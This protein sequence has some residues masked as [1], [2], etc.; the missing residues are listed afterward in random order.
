MFAKYVWADLIRNPRRTLSTMIGV[1][2]GV[3]L[4]CAILFFVDG[5]SS[6]MTE[7]A[8]SPLPIDIQLVQTDPV[9][10]DTRLAL[11]VEPT[12][13]ATPGD[14]INVR[15][16]VRNQ[17][18]TP[19]NEVVVRSIPASGLAYRAGSA[20]MD[21]K[22]MVDEGE[23][24]FAS[25]PAKIGLNI[26]TVE[27]G[28]TVNLGYQVTVSQARDISVDAFASTISTREA[29]LPV[30]A[31]AGKLPGLAE[32]AARI[33]ALDGVSSAEQLSFV[34]LPHGSLSATVPVN[35]L[36]RL[37]GFDSSYTAQDRTITIVEGTQAPGEA[38]ISAEAARSLSVGIHDSIS[39]ML[40]DGTRL[41]RRISGIVDLTRARS[42]FLS[43]M[44]ENLE[45][46][47]YVPDSIVIDAAT[48]AE[49]V[50]PAFERVN[51]GRGDRI[52][53]L[54]LREVDVYVRRDLLEAEP[55]AALARTE[56]I[57]AAV[58]SV[59]EDHQ[60]GRVEDRGVNEQS[61]LLDNISNTLTVARDDAAVAKRMFLFLSI[62]GAMLAAL[63]GAYAGIVL[64][65]AQR[66]EQATLRV[67]GASR[68]NLLWMLW[69]RVGWITAGG[70][71]LGL[72]LGYASVAAVLGRSMLTRVTAESLIFSGVLG[73]VFGLMATGAA[74]YWTGRSTIDRGIQMDRLGPSMQPPIWQRYRLDLL[75]LAALLVATVI[76]LST[77]GFE[78]TPGSVYEG[79]AVEL[80]L[81]LLLLPIAAWVAGSLFGGRLFAWLLS[82][83]STRA[84][85]GSVSPLS[86]LYWRSLKRRSSSLVVA[87]LILGM[88]VALA[89]SLAVFTASYDAAKAADARYTVGSDLKII[90]RPSSKHVFRSADAST[91]AVEGIDTVVPVIYGIHNTQLRSYRNT[92][93][94]NLAALDPIAYG[95]VAPFDDAHFSNDSA[96][97][98]LSILANQP[99]AILLSE[100]M[101]EF[102][103]VREGDTIGVLLGRATAEQV[104][105][106]MKVQGLYERLPGFPDG[107]DALMN[108]ER[109]Q[110]AVASAA[111]AFFLGQTSDSSDALVE[112]T[113][114]TLRNGPGAGDA[115]RLDTRLTALGKDQSSLASLNINGL[116]KLDS[117]YSLA[118][119]T[120]TVA[121]FV[122]G[123]LLQ[124]RREYVTLR[125]QGM[126]PRAIQTFIGAEAGTAA[127]V[128]CSVGALVGLMM[129]Y[130]FINVLRPLFVLEPLYVV[131]LSSLSAIL[132]SVLA[133]TVVTSVAASALV[134]QLQAME[135]LRDE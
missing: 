39:V 27:A 60:Q 108:I 102:M 105:I 120:V 110:K 30:N 35:G 111:P 14:V 99:D 37:F 17:G 84:P 59:T 58:V 116:L 73:T 65:G 42:L 22:A 104:Q 118:M 124:R 9:S 98:S 130:Y 33:K 46:F 113:T 77:S 45:L 94:A 1:I 112:Q 115:L 88:I 81:G 66:R 48:F 133:A 50:V 21:S 121:I 54:P 44:G 78:G 101:A 91:L 51:T 76:A 41:E 117:A 103:G 119:G 100:D 107:V 16:T 97:E 20:E 13:A 89:T 28:A 10:G 29:I 55:V 70:A 19:A 23:N 36:V 5:L 18:K 26:G 34:D 2:L 8:V 96:E 62:P 71:G 135:L 95:K 93:V 64:A 69:L 47:V 129:A 32:L 80:S 123:L 38:L 72:V 7:R 131:P 68:R 86:L 56:R 63:L 87:T 25:G 49:V 122:F 106:D 82:R 114:E 4:A 67:R 53:S 75:G 74:L 40:P 15:L 12:G 90:P 126:L 11:E 57:A 132:G 43:R 92:D 127:V 3:G 52:K 85:Q 128:G 31:N 79:R 109:Y 6:S 83:L 134:N 61:F 125:A 24:P